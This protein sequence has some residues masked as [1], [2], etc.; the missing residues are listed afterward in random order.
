MDVLSEVLK[1]VRLDGALFYNGEFSAPWSV[2]S[3]A[4][5]VVAPYVST[6]AR[7]LILYHLLTEGRAYVRLED[8]LPV[9]LGPGDIVI[10]PHGDPHIMGNGGPIPPADISAELTRVF[11]QRLKLSRSGGG[12]EITR[13]V[14]GYMA[15]DPHVSKTLLGALPRL[16]RVE[17]GN[18][19]AGKWLEDSIRLS[20]MD[21]GESRAG[22]EAVR[23]RL[24][25]V[26]LVEA[27]RRYVSV[28]PPEATGWL[29]GARD[30]QIGAALTMLHR[31]PSHS[32]TLQGLARS[33][34]ISRSVL[35]ERFQQCIGEAPMAYLTRWRLL[36]AAQQLASSNHGVARIA[37]D[38]GYRSEAAFNRAFKREFGVPPARFRDRSKAN[39]GR[40][41]APG[42]RANNPEFLS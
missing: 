37:A 31:D 26:L 36:L 38:V 40:R 13:F 35:A 24:S 14:C 11:S 21:E 41:A 18:D 27:L 7:H 5:S 34:G 19:A 12:G 32:W 15:C 23:A 20:A 28:L 3:P 25:E 4:S 1:V 10:F 33:T 8:G 29:A 6:G 22:A 16:L 30:A 9:D 42:E 39:D 2:R 17:I